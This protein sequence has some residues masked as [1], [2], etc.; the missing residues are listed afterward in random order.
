MEEWMKDEETLSLQELV[1]LHNIVDSPISVLDLETG[2]VWRFEGKLRIVISVQYENARSGPV[3][4]VETVD[5]LQRFAADTQVEVWHANGA[6]FFVELP[7]EYPGSY[8]PD[9]G[10]G[11]S[12][13]PA[14]DAAGIVPVWRGPKK[15][16]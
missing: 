7:P 16:N 14:H 5:G 12:A 2:M 1:R 6:P 3:A 9:A 13:T 10:G 8:T 15:V 4:V 11:G